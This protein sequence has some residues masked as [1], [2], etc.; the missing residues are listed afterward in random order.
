MKWMKAVV[1]SALLSVA[2]PVF[3][4]DEA[5]ETPQDYA[6]GMMLEAT[7]S[8]PWYRVSLP[9]ALYQ[10]SAWPDLR[11][12]RVFNRQGDTVPFALTAQKTP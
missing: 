5:P 10:Q 6:T 4:R 8:S 12:V 11:D 9:L 1:W 7:G 3:S 2:W